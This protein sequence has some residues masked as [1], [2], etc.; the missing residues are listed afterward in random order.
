MKQHAPPVKDTAVA[1]VLAVDGGVELIVASDRGEE[2]LA[3]RQIVL[4]DG[5]GRELRFA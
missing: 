2:Q 1:I 5:V 4:R 3:R